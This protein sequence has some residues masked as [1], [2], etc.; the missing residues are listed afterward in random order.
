M[1]VK[2]ITRTIIFIITLH[3]LSGGFGLDR[4]PF[5]NEQSVSKIETTTL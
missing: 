5:G 1:T 4:L 3:P 2:I